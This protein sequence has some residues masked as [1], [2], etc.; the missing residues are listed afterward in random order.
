MLFWTLA[1]SL[2][3]PALVWAQD[4]YAGKR[5]HMV[6]TQIEARGVRDPGVLEV[7]RR[8]PRHLFMPEGVRALAY[9]DQPVP[10]GYGQTISQP[11]IV[12]F[13]TELLAPARNHKVLEIGTGSGYQAAVLAGLVEHVYSIEIVPE[14]AR[15][16]AASLKK[17]RFDNVTVR[18]GDGYK[19]WP[20]HAPFDRIILTAAPPRVPQ[21]L[22]DQLKPGGRLVAPEGASVFG[23]ELVVIEKAAN[24]KTT[25]KSVLPVMFVPMVRG[26][27]KN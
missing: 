13:M 19:G 10:V 4:P 12:G 27:E 6:R 26:P 22:I 7:M 2:A 23:Q 16:A 3:L 14:L 8:V 24:G 18:L 20:E 15:S 5:E 17:L 11:Y 9:A 25:K 1:A 21:E